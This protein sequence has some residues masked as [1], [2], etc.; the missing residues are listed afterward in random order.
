M[1]NIFLTA[2]FALVS[3]LSFGQTP[4]D[5]I[6]CD[7]HYDFHKCALVN[8]SN[9]TLVYVTKYEIFND[10]FFPLTDDN[11]FRAEYLIADSDRGTIPAYD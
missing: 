4:L 10:G 6:L 8:K 11:L 5:N 2:V 1:K 3:I 9:D 7:C